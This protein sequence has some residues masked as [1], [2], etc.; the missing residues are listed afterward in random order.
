MNPH[1]FG[2]K[3]SITRMDGTQAAGGILAALIALG[4]CIGAFFSCRKRA[5]KETHGAEA[6]EEEGFNEKL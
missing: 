1:Y 2:P 3:L 6:E 4:L 5:I